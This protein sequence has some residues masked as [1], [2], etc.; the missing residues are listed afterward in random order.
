MITDPKNNAPGETAKDEYVLSVGELLTLIWKRLWIIGLVVILFVGAAVGASLL[1]TPQYEASVRILVGQEG[2]IT[3]TPNDTS[4][5]QQLTETMAVA[6]DSRPVAEAVIEDL[7]LQLESGEL[8][9][10]YSVEP[11]PATQFIEITYQDPDPETARLVANSLGEQ[12]SQQIDEVSTSA[13][14]I[15]ATLYET[16]G[17]PTEPVSPDP[18]RNGVLA[19]V[20]AIMCGVGLAFLLEYMDDSWHSPEEA[21][22]ISGVP[23]FGVVPAFGRRSQKK[24]KSPPAT[25]RWLDDDEEDYTSNGSG[26][27][28][29]L[30]PPA[31][32]RDS[33]GD[34]LKAGYRQVARSGGVAWPFGMVLVDSEGKIEEVNP[35][36]REMLG[37]EEDEFLGEPFAG[38]AAHPDDAQ[39]NAALHEDLLS[40]ERDRYQMEKRYV[41]K[42]GQLTWTRLSVS[43]V[44][45]SEETSRFAVGMIEDISG[46]KQVEE[47]LTLSREAQR[48]SE[49]RLRAVVEQSPLIV[50]TF[51]PDGSPLLANAAWERFWDTKEEENGGLNVFEDEKLRDAG[52]SSYVERSL[53]GG[54]AVT[55]PVLRYEPEGRNGAGPYWLRA[56]IHPVCDEAGR[57]LEVALA[58]EDVTGHRHAED[59]L[60]E[61]TARSKQMEEALRASEERL[62]TLI[63]YATDNTSAWD[64]EDL[65]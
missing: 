60:K 1:Q 36:L 35:A 30:E 38:F 4:G 14:P 47:E 58:I 63:R 64:Q 54:E 12:F 57:V 51:A 48:L 2:G 61:N 55:T 39:T 52:L 21:E 29:E 15:T 26:N 10:R 44:Q 25:D 18:L 28:R 11:V 34:L 53:S 19:L 9:Q 46:Q 62:R 43:S 56:Y 3:E 33:N 16:A 42:D 65:R 8:S 13:N 23:T 31:D 24:S 22:R 32:H 6:A 17:T 49:G 45:D 59:A 40:G 20:L 27:G 7:N 37:F 41:K 50:R 5:L